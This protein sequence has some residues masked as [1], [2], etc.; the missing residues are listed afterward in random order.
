MSWD[1][2]ESDLQGIMRLDGQ[3]NQPDAPHEKTR[4]QRFL[5]VVWPW[6]HKGSIWA[7]AGADL[8]Q[9]YAK[10]KIAN[11]NND[12]AKKGAEAAEKAAEADLKRQEVVKVCN[13][14]ITRIFMDDSLPS[15][16]KALQLAN[17]VAANP[18]IAAQLEKVRAMM[19]T[20]HWKRGADVQIAPLELPKPEVPAS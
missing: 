5:D 2:E 3:P 13:E 18:Q 10:A 1:A 11:E 17:V 15:G 7:V 19:E 8:A 9:D 12:A 4:W 14:E 6:A 16:A 20:L